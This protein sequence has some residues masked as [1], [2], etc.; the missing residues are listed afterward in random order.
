MA[1]SITSLFQ[2]PLHPAQW[3]V[4]LLA[5]ALGA[6]WD[7]RTGRIPNWLTGPLL[8]SGLLWAFIVGGAGALGWSV[9]G[10]LLLAAPFV[11]LFV[12]AGG[13]AGDAKMMAAMGAWTGLAPGAAI[14]LSVVLWGMVLAVVLTF[15]RGEQ[16]AVTANLTQTVNAAMLFIYSRGRAGDVK[17]TAVQSRGTSPL[18]YGVAIFLGTCTAAVGGQLWAA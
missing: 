4:V 16:R 1:M 13:G 18:P 17:E 14:L 10:M 2:Q 3:A 12:Y 15:I 11:L 6:G 8:L 5:A 7:W 9:W